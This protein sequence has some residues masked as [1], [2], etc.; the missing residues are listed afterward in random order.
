M[1]LCTNGKHNGKMTPIHN[2]RSRRPEHSLCWKQMR[3]D[4]TFYCIPKTLLLFPC[5]SYPRLD[6]WLRSDDAYLAAHELTATQ[7]HCMVPGVYAVKYTALAADSDEML[8]V[9]GCV[10]SDAI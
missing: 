10:A 1:H 7:K 2:A 3:Q 4:E 5:F 6:L 9:Y 8:V